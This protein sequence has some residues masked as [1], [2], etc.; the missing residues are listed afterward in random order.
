MREQDKVRSWMK[1]RGLK[2]RELAGLI[3]VTESMM[4]RFLRG[5]R[6]LGWRPLLKLARVMGVPLE[7]FFE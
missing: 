7:S 1:S 3:G 4:S 6:F 5:T 2:Q